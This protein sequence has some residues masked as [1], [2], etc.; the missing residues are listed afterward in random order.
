MTEAP[1]IT[2][3]KISSNLVIDAGYPARMNKLHDGIVQIFLF[4]VAGN[5]LSTVIKFKRK[6]LDTRND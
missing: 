3:A 1:Q 4:V 2:H 5:V 6:T